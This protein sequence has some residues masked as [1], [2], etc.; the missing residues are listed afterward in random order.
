MNA[1]AQKAIDNLSPAQ[2]K[3]Y[4]ERGIIKVMT[5]Q[6]LPTK[7]EET[8]EYRKH[9]RL[10]GQSIH[11][12]E[13]SRKYNIAQPTLSRWVKRGVIKK[14][15]VEKNRIILDESFVAYAAEVMK[16]HPQHQGR[17]LFGENGMPYAPTKTKSQ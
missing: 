5:T 10:A 8:P 16:E 14:L 15:G 7:I 1:Q 4:V 11:L 12:S 13:A 2:L 17:W 9:K 6:S 3:N